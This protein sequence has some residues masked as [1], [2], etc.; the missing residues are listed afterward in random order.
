MISDSELPLTDN[1]RIITE[2]KGNEML[3]IEKLIAH[4]RDQSLLLPRLGGVEDF[5]VITWFS[6]EVE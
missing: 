5:G 6:G 3:L 4:G 1:F 2:K